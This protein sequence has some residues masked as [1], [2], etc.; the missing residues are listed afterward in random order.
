[1]IARMASI[2]VFPGRAEG[3][4]PEPKATCNPEKAQS[5]FLRPRCHESRACL[6]RPKKTRIVPFTAASPQTSAG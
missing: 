1:M 4:S 2:C 3:E 6:R 5:L